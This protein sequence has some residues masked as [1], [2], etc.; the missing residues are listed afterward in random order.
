MWTI[1]VPR[2]SGRVLSERCVS[3]P[4]GANPSSPFKS[5]TQ[6]QGC[7]VTAPSM[8]LLFLGSPR[9]S[10]LVAVPHRTSLAEGNKVGE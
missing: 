1:S 3:Y 5:T 10:A 9:P 8:S 7:L 6:S 2:C 4:N